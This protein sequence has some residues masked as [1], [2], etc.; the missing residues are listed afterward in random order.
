MVI[1]LGF[2]V[3]IFKMLNITLFDAIGSVITST[4]IYLVATMCQ[5]YSIIQ[6]Y[7]NNVLARKMFAINI[8]LIWKILTLC[9]LVF[10]KNTC[11]QNWL[12]R[13][14]QRMCLQTPNLF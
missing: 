11:F 7:K 2:P 3:R 8:I 4:N 12:A 10:K 5:M 13:E 6:V 14:M 9:E 1:S